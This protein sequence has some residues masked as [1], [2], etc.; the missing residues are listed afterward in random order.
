M[1]FN[2]RYEIDIVIVEILPD[3]NYGNIYND[4]SE[5]KRECPVSEHRF[6]YCV[7]DRKTGCVPDECNDWNDT[8]E[9]A[10]LDY[11]NNCLS[12]KNIFYIDIDATTRLPFYEAKKKYG[13][14]LFSDKVLETGYIVKRKSDGK[15]YKFIDEFKTYDN[16]HIVYEFEE[17]NIKEINI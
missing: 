5:F 10:I 3:G 13:M 14:E 12:D 6:G 16:H 15:Y 9:E 17:I 7:I 2:K 1:K 8:V 11:E 4:M